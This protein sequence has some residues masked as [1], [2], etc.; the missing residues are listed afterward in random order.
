MLPRL[1]IGDY[2][3]VAKWPYG[4]SRYS[5][6]FGLASFDGRLF[7][8]E[9]E[10]G[11]VV[12]FRYP[13]E[14]RGLCE[15]RDRPSRRHG[16]RCAAASSSSTARPVPKVRIADYLMPITPNSPCRYVEPAPGAG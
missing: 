12:V 14:R 3:F 4:Y 9:P 6:P 10:R 8:A 1:M 5:F 13:G 7:A 16:R 2:L 11:D 15:A